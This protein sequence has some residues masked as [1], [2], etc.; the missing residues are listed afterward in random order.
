LLFCS[1]FLRF[2]INIYYKNQH[3]KWV[4]TLENHLKVKSCKPPKKTHE[5]KYF[6]IVLCMKFKNL[7]YFLCM[8]VLYLVQGKTRI[9]ALRKYT[10]L[11]SAAELSYIFQYMYKPAQHSQG[12]DP[13]PPSTRGKAGRNHLNEDIT[14]LLLSGIGERFRQTVSN[15]GHA[16]LLRRCELTL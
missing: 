9:L 14:P 6:L 13:P 3:S 2:Q 8:T 1:S 11:S 7:P 16:A 5:T 4:E 10:S 12:V 15:L